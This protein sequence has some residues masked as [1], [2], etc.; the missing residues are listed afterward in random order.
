MRGLPR[1]VVE[2]PALRCLRTGTQCQGLVDKAVFG[3]RLI[4]MISETFSNL[5]DTNSYFYSF[6]Y[7]FSEWSHAL[8]SSAARLAWCTL[9]S[10][11]SVKFQECNK[12][13]T[14]SSGSV[15]EKRIFFSNSKTCPLS[16]NGLWHRL[17]LQLDRNI[18]K[19]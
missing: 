9:Y 14:A 7:E 19:Q 5:A 4:F 18:H 2:S 17:C 10:R 3:H 13:E 12:L 11:D 16:A 6:I 1:D 15:L 8:K